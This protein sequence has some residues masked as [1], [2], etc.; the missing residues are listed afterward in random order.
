MVRGREKWEE[1]HKPKGKRDRSGGRDRN[2]EE[3]KEWE[4]TKEWGGEGDKGMGR[5]GR[6]KNGEERETN[7][8]GE[9][10]KW[11][12]RTGDIG[13]E[14]N[15]L[16]KGDFEDTITVQNVSH[17][18]QHGGIDNSYS[19]GMR[20]D[21]QKMFPVLRKIECLGP[22]LLPLRYNISQQP[23]NRTSLLLR[24]VHC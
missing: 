13:K 23:D 7:E 2:G 20:T 16:Q 3:E 19:K 24:V 10:Q 22:K 21:E 18:I 4:E 5:R 6:Q 14:R 17:L 15:E 9:G 1:D 11:E 12:E 8:W